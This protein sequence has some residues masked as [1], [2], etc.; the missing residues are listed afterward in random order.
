MKII[1]CLFLFVSFTVFAQSK[2]GISRDEA[3]IN[4]RLKLSIPYTEFIERYKA[5]D[6]TDTALP[7]ETCSKDPDVKLLYYKGITFEWNK[8][9]LNFMSIDFSKRKRMFLSITDDWFD[10]TTSLKYF[11]KAYPEE[12][13]YT[14]DYIDYD[15]VEYSRIIFLPKDLAE[16]YEWWFLFIKDKLHS[17]EYH[18]LCE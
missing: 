8:D 14:E 10:N 7:G 11:T 5:A 18:I 3:R 4:G 13:A 16:N 15:G 9:T 2:N 1:T 12:S 6:S 17:I